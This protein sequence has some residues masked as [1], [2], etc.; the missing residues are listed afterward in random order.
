[1]AVHGAVGL[2]VGH[3]RQRAV[4]EIVEEIG[5]VTHMVSPHRRIVQLILKRVADVAIDSV[6]RSARPGNIVAATII[7]PRDVLRAQEIA[8]A[9]HGDWRNGAGLA[10]RALR[11]PGRVYVYRVVIMA[12]VAFCLQRVGQLVEVI[13]DWLY[14]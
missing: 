3:R 7:L 2:D 4:L 6:E 14:P 5:D 1:M 12:G 8:N 11:R 9:G 13:Q 10:W